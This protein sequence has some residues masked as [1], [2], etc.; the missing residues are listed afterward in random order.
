V[1]AAIAVTFV[2][3]LLFAAGALSLP[4]LLERGVE[5]LIPGLSDG[6]SRVQ[7]PSA[8]AS[9]SGTLA[10]AARSGSFRANVVL[11]PSS[12]RGNHALSV[13]SST[14]RHATN[15]RGSRAASVKVRG[16]IGVS[17]P[18]VTGTSPSTGGSPSSGAGGP[19]DGTGGSGSGSPGS[20]G[21]GTPAVSVGVNGTTTTVNVE[22]ADTN[23]TGTAIVSGSTP[24]VS[25]EATIG[26][27]STGAGVSAPIAS[28][29]ISVATV[30]TVATT[31]TTVTT[32]AVSLPAGDNAVVAIPSGLALPGG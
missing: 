15:S 10:G 16:V 5:S 22:T 18:P 20:A 12:D 13:G 27:A 19:S 31:V 11:P 23:V 1:L 14:S 17:V 30:A 8:T 7:Q 25:A 4:A 6:N 2:P 24:E 32:P 9:Y 29:E 21:T 3:L 26:D 28:S